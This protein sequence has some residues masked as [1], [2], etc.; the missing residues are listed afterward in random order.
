MTYPMVSSAVRTKGYALWV[1]RMDRWV[2]RIRVSA[3]HGSP[4]FDPQV[5]SQTYCG[6]ANANSTGLPARIRAFNTSEVLANN[7]TLFV[8]QLPSAVFGFFLVSQ[9]QTFV[10]NYLGSQGNLCLGGSIGRFNSSSQIY[11]SSV[12]G[13]AHLVMNV[14][15]VPQPQSLVDIQAGETWNFQSWFRDRNPNSTSNFSDGVAV[16]FW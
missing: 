5:V 1:Q 8:D 2:A 13:A 4:A 6:P 14:T 9:D 12:N 11:Q 3:T 16:T 15:S 10:P 7:T